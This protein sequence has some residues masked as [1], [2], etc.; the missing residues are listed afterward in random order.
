MYAKLINGALRSAPKRVSYNGC[1]VLA[2]PPG[3]L[4]ELGYLPVQ[5]TDPPADAPAGQHYEPHWEQTDAAIVQA[6]TL[7]ADPDSP[8]PEPT[9]ADLMAAVE[10][11]LTT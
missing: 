6:W 7:S 9:M 3:I 1:T 4:M 2:P 10:R 8:E 5:H 11:G